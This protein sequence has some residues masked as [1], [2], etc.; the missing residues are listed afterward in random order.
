MMKDQTDAHETLPIETSIPNDCRNG[1]NL[2]Y[3]FPLMMIPI[4]E[5]FP[6]LLQRDRECKKLFQIQH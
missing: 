1:E 3:S 6:N 5:K 2:K 4:H